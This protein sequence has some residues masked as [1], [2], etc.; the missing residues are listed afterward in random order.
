MIPVPAASNLQDGKSRLAIAQTMARTHLD[1]MPS[2]S[3][4]AVI[5]GSGESPAPM[6]PDLSASK[7]AERLVAEPVTAPLNERLRSALRLHLDDRERVTAER[8][9]AGD[10]FLREIYVLTDLAARVG[11]QPDAAHGLRDELATTPD[12]GFG[13]FSM[14][15]PSSQQ[16]SALSGRVRCGPRSHKAAFLKLKPVCGPW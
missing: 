4:A 13:I 2:G 1:G 11:R 15:E 5:T 14:S 12:I 6:T 3:K 9:A 16:T 8:G 10:R 7:S